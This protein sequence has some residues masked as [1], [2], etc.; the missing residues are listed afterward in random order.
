MAEGLTKVGAELQFASSPFR[1]LP[2][3]SEWDHLQFLYWALS[4]GDLVEE[5]AA[6]YDWARRKAVI[7]AYEGF[8][9]LDPNEQIQEAGR[10]QVRVILAEV[11]KLEYQVLSNPDPILKPSDVFH[12]VDW[13][14]TKQEAYAER[15]AS[16]LD[17]SV[18]TPEEREIMI[19]A[20]DIQD[21]LL[22][23]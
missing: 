1:K 10:K 18:L 3:E 13:A 20:K 16:M 15:R 22:K 12:G 17:W 19:K 11:A 23:G 6:R 14:L 7:H 21:R 4:S 9:E 8:A 5:L 2:D